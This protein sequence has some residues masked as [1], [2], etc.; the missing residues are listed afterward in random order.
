MIDARIGPGA[1]LCDVGKETQLKAGARQLRLQ[2][3]NGERGFQVRTLCYRRRRLLEF[4][5]DAAKQL[6]PLFPR[7]PS[8]DFE[9]LCRQLRRTIHILGRR[10]KEI[11]LQFPAGCR[12]ES[13]K[14]IRAGLSA[15]G[16]SD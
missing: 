16:A 6:R 5:G 8:V 1:F 13:T 4:R 14:L 15:A 2:A 9:S 10:G 12:V 11:R 7:E 3:R